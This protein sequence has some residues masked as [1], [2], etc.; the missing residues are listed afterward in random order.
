MASSCYLWIHKRL[1]LSHL[2][3]D[4]AFVDD[5]D[6]PVDV[7]DVDLGDDV[8]KFKFKPPATTK[9]ISYG[10][11][12]VAKGNLF[13]AS[14]KK[15]MEKPVSYIFFQPFKPRQDK[16]ALLLKIT[17][18]QLHMQFYLLLSKLL[19]RNATFRKLL[20]NAVL[21]GSLHENMSP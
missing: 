7:R 14:L 12:H 9:F 6:V 13:V 8:I 10:A 17:V 18:L 21:K 3:V 20:P 15:E 11:G 16:H 2:N 1:D 19:L 4:D 5:L